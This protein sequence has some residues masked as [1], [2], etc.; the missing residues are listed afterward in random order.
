MTVHEPVLVRE[1][2]ERLV[3]RP[4]GVYVDATVGGGGHAQAIL[5]VL[6]PTGRVIGLDRDPAALAQLASRL[7]KLD[8]RMLLV[9]APASQLGTVLRT[10][11]VESVDGV[12]LDLGLSSDQL[13]S[14]R[15]FAFDGPGELDLRF[16]PTAD[17]PTARELIAVLGPERLAQALVEF[18]DFG[19]RQ[20]ARFAALLSAAAR[21][22][23]LGSVT[24][25]RAQLEP[26]VPF[27]WRART[28]A[29]V[30]QALRILVNDELNELSAALEAARQA[31][32]GGGVLCVI[33]Y[34]SLEDR[35]VKRFLAP[36]H[37]PRPDAPPPP[38]WPGGAFEVVTRRPIRPS[39]SE[40]DA[41]PRARSAKLRVGRRRG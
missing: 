19:R 22:G 34:H 7:A 27:R 36:P 35:L 37:L 26:V 41:N 21:R 31:L 17:L 4:T 8:K 40:V 18:G 16:D 11:G 2:V 6:R 33:S 39:A 3:T 29:R 30:F 12:L 14:R 24:E 32:V 15:G 13:A 9:H 28:F 25:L 20:A 1:V 10:Q 23:A 38:G 5:N